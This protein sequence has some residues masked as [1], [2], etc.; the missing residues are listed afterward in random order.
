MANGNSGDCLD[1]L[2]LEIAFSTISD[3]MNTYWDSAKSLIVMDN[4]V[5]RTKVRGDHNHKGPFALAIGSKFPSLH[6]LFKA[7]KSTFRFYNQLLRPENN[8]RLA[9]SVSSAGSIG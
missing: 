3:D 9:G 5:G 1:L 2:G 4:V 7:S 8:G 6:K